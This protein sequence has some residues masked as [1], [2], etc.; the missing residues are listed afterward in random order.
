[1][2]F[3][4][5]LR[6]SPVPC[7][8]WCHV[9]S[10]LISYFHPHIPWALAQMGHSLVP[11]TSLTS[12]T[13]SL[14]SGMFV[15][16]VTV[17][18]LWFLFPQPKLFPS[19]LH[20]AAPS[21]LRFPSPTANNISLIRQY[22]FYFC[23]DICHS[24]ILSCVLIFVNIRCW[25]PYLTYISLLRYILKQCLAQI[26]I[27]IKTPLRHLLNEFIVRVLAGQNW[28]SIQVASEAK[29]TLPHSHPNSFVSSTIIIY[30]EARSPGKKHCVR[31][32]NPC[33]NF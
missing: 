4:C 26:D 25:E 22:F 30:A 20:Q 27:V 8:S 5:W 6:T 28:N 29:C 1:M 9:C 23:S 14:Y 3:Y 33:L 16:W 21:D 17:T 24:F 15:D 12:G 19:F 13:C 7:T 18:L 10:F 32:W 31:S 11:F 2:I